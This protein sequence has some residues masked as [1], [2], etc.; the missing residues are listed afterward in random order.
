MLE[1]QSD[2]IGLEWPEKSNAQDQYCRKPNSQ[3]Q[4]VWRM[5]YKLR[6][7]SK[8]ANDETDDQNDKNGRAITAVDGTETLPTS[9]TRLRD[10]QKAL[11][12]FPLSASRAFAGKPGA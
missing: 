3:L 9:I 6:P 1:L 5:E 2:Q 11:K 8:A 10:I 12:K 7:D 4:P